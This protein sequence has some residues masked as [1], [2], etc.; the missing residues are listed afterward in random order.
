V[1]DSKGEV[2]GAVETF[3]D[4][5]SQV[6]MRQDMETL[7][8]LAL[9]DPLTGLAN[10]R[11][12]NAT[13][14]SKIDEF[15]RYGLSFGL[16]F[17]DIDWFK[18]INDTYGHKVGD[19]VLRMVA[20]TLSKNVRPF[21]LMGRWGGEEFVGIIANVDE[22]RLSSLAHRLR[23]LVEQSSLMVESDTVSVTISVGATLSSPGDT[24]ETIMER[25]DRLMF[26]SKDSGRNRV[27]TDFPSNKPNIKRLKKA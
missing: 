14:R 5:S 3:S 21:D 17:I 22:K 25:A 6:A 23:L 10:R 12:V 18:R 24:M 16:L 13:L 15:K 26:K 8:K 19:D 2:V 27:S 9:I 20:N 11:S 7:Q 1:R 4:N